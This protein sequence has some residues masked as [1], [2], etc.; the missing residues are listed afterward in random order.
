YVRE[1]SARPGLAGHHPGVGHGAVTS[2]PRAVSD[3]PPSSSTTARTWLPGVSG[4][5]SVAAPASSTHP[6]WGATCAAAASASPCSTA[7]RGSPRIAAVERTWTTR[8]STSGSTPR[9]STPDGTGRHGPTTNAAA[10]V[11]SAITSGSV[12][13]NPVY[14][15]SITSSAGATD[16]YPSWNPP[17][18]QCS[19][20]ATSC[21]HPGTTHRPTYTAPH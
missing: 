5:A 1:P 12:N 17:V 19:W 16:L 15:E 10:E 13:R 8:P 4:T 6:G 21:S 11:L 14:R 7:R 9:L 20:H 18:R 2:P 3:A